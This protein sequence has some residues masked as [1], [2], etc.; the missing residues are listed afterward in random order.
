MAYNVNPLAYKGVVRAQWLDDDRF[1]Y[2]DCR[3]ERRLLY[4]GRSR[5]GHAAAAFD[6]ATLAAALHAASAPSTAHALARQEA[7]RLHPRLEPLGPRHGH[8][9]GNPA[10]H[11]RREGLRLRHRQR[12][13]EHSDAAIL[14]W[15][16]D[17][18]KIA[19]FQQDQRKTGEMY[20]VP[21]TN[22]HPTLKAW[23]YPLVGDKDV[24]MIERVVIDV[25]TQPKSSA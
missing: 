22:S 20:L 21:V 4:S 8:R 5:Q 6:Q 11:R 3:R 19:T 15:S 1:W 18:K 2:R 23:K 16:P 13:L 17:S 12:R 10:H 7:R 24:T 9:R 25:P 14:L